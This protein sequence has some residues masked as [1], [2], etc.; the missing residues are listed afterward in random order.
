MEAMVER[1]GA[2]EDGL[3]GCCR[4][5]SANAYQ[6]MNDLHLQHC[7]DR[8]RHAADCDYVDKSLQ[9]CN[10]NRRRHEQGNTG[11]VPNSVG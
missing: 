3:Y 5:V 11:H 8:M 6:I 1:R 9:T 7:E 4:Q 10:F 2:P